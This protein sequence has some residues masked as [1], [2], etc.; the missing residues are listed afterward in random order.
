MKRIACFVMFMLIASLFF[1]RRSCRVMMQPYW[2][3]GHNKVL[4]R[5]SEEDVV[6]ASS[7]YFKLLTL[8]KYTGISFG[9][10]KC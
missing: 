1:I 2:L 6:V 8:E 4:R 5:R 10:S 9:V 7:T 3:W